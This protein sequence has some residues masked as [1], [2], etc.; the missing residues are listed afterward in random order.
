MNIAEI[1][2]KNLRGH[3]YVKARGLVSIFKPRHDCPTC[4]QQELLPAVQQ[5]TDLHKKRLEYL[6]SRPKE[7]ITV[8]FPPPLT[9]EEQKE[10]DEYIKRWNLPF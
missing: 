6:Q 4:K 7:P 8:W 5:I 2:A 3:D 10:Q 9:E 1:L